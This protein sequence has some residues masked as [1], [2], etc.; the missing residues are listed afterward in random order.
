MF[1]DAKQRRYR[2]ILVLEDDSFF[3]SKITKKTQR[4][5]TFV[6]TK[7]PMLHTGMHAHIHHTHELPVS[8]EVGQFA[9]SH[10]M[11]FHQR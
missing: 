11:I 9:G 6:T 7:P 5:C 3:S 8:F 10:A 2:N 4:I 1:W